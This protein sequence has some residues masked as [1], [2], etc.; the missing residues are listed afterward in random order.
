MNLLAFFA[1][2]LFYWVE[3]HAEEQLAH[4]AMKHWAVASEGNLEVKAVQAEKDAE[5]RFRWVK[6]EHRSLY[7]VSVPRVVNGK[8]VYDLVIN[9][10]MAKAE[11]D[12]LSAVTILFLTCVHES[13]HAL[14]LDHTSEF[15]DI[16]YNFQFGGDLAEYFARYRRKLKVKA[17]TAK[18]SPIAKGDVAQLRAVLDKRMRSEKR[19]GGDAPGLPQ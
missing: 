15:A 16:M 1:V 8:R 9:P 12:P 19:S 6:P 2:T 3:P 13:G 10:E 4:D 5:L 14:G 17:D 11:T 7:G 18:F